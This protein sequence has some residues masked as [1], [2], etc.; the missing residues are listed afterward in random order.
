MRSTMIQLFAPELYP[1]SKAEL[2]AYTI[3]AFRVAQRSEQLSL[4]AMPKPIID[5]LMKDSAVKYWKTKEWLTEESDGYHLSAAGLVVCQSALA[6]ELPTHNTNV[7]NVEYWL[8]QF[9]NNTALP[10]SGQFCS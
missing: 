3:A 4:I 9:L 6:G 8:G 2:R 1:T 5:F 7:T 10:R